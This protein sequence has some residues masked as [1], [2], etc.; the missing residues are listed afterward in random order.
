MNINILLEN[1]FIF[2]Y[3][4]AKKYNNNRNHKPIKEI[5][6]ISYS[7]NLEYKIKHNFK[8]KEKINNEK[9]SINSQKNINYE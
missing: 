9:E 2:I 4:T 5:N 8:N 3:K 6:E 1:L 7:K